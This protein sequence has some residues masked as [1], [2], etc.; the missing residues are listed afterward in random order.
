MLEVTAL[1]GASEG[2]ELDL[3]KDEPVGVSKVDLLFVFAFLG[4]VYVASLEPRF[5][6]VVTE[7]RVAATTLLGPLDDVDA[8]GAHE[9]VQVILEFLETLLVLT[10]RDYNGVWVQ[11]RMV[12]VVGLS[13][14]LWLVAQPIRVLQVQLVSLWHFLLLHKAAWLWLWQLNSGCLHHIHFLFLKARSFNLSLLDRIFNRL[15]WS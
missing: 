6:A 11:H 1:V 2:Q 8:Y 15:V 9:K 14:L 5:E 10:W 7:Q 4:A 13:I 12:V 3:L